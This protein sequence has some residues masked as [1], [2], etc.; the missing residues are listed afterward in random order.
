MEYGYFYQIRF[1]KE[2]TWRRVLVHEQTL[3][4]DFYLIAAS[5]MEVQEVD[6]SIAARKC[7]KVEFQ[8]KRV[9]EVFGQVGSKIEV[10]IPLKGCA[11][12]NFITASICA[13]LEEKTKAPNI[14]LGPQLIKTEITNEQIEKPTIEAINH[15]LA[16]WN[17]SLHEI[18][19]ARKNDLGIMRLSNF[20]GIGIPYRFG[21][22]EVAAVIEYT[23][24]EHPEILKDYISYKEMLVVSKLIDFGFEQELFS[25]DEISLLKNAQFV[26]GYS[27][28]GSIKPFAVP[29]NVAYLLHDY[30]RETPHDLSYRKKC[31]IEDCFSGLIYLYG[32]L[33]PEKMVQMLS[34]YFVLEHQ[35]VQ[36]FIKAM[37]LSYR[38]ADSIFVVESENG[39]IIELAV[40]YKDKDEI[41][42]ATAYNNKDYK[43]FTLEEIFAASAY[44]YY[45]QNDYSNKIYL[46]L[47]EKK[48]LNI[49]IEIRILW[50]LT[51]SGF[52]VENI[53]DDIS[54]NI[55]SKYKIDIFPT[56]E[57]KALFKSYLQAY[58]NSIPRWINK[59]YSFNSIQR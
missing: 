52:D 36:E 23:I 9:R 37:R 48:T 44:N 38:V 13:L 8:K 34:E 32:Y 59:G 57:D 25:E 21:P 12:P 14:K 41:I 22:L 42:F 53:L 55:F 20:L 26:R 10:K 54:G 19:I 56:K 11:E 15:S 46:F 33:S 50:L 28:E 43:K 35:D 31:D 5:V 24:F 39:T 30:I 6:Y 58:A 45:F 47:K 7:N 2:A 1:S 27:N 29:A 3:M 4:H 18:I 49:E 16:L 51:Q 17:F 40:M